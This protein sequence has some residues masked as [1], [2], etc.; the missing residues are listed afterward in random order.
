LQDAPETSGRIRDLVAAIAVDRRRR[1]QHEGQATQPL[2]IRGREVGA[3]EVRLSRGR[4]EHG[5]R[6]SAVPADGGD[7]LHV[8]RVDVRTLL[9]VHLDVDE[10]LVHQRRDLLV[11]E[12]L[13]RHH[14]A[15]VAGAVADAQQDGPILA[16]GA[17]EGLLTP[18]VPVHRV[19]CVLEEIWTGL[20]GE[21][22]GHASTL[23]DSGAGL[24]VRPRHAPR[25]MDRRFGARV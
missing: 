19:V 16:A 22:V 24:V 2:P 10:E 6:P 25:S 11:L 17:G 8:H 7:S 4:E 15:P 9:A 20:G 14:V 3:A 12:A 1:I 23:P 13:V 21:A 18:R 5:H